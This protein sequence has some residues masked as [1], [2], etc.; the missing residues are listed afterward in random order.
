MLTLRS[1]ALL[2]EGGKVC[3]INSNG[4]WWVGQYFFVSFG[5]LTGAQKYL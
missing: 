1:G 2:E 4:F 3:Q 5:T